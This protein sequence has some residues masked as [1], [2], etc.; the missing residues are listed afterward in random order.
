MVTTQTP[1]ISVLMAVRNGAAFIDEALAS[2]AG[3]DFKDFEIVLVD[4]G[5]GDDT[6]RLVS[7]WVDDEPRLRAF[8]LD[9]PGLSR[10]L[11]YAAAMARAPF[12]A[13]LD[14]D[15]IAL[16][17]RLGVQY[18]AMQNEPALGL[19]GSFVELIGGDGR[20]I[21]ERQLPVSDREIKHIL[22]SANPFVHSTIMMRRDAYARAGGYREGLRIC[23]DFDLWCRMAEVT[24]L[25]NLDVPLVR[26]R[27]HGDAM[28]FRQATRVALV[29]TCIVA[30]QY[31]RR[32]GE[33]EP[34]DRGMPKLRQAL[35]LLHMPRAVV[36]YRVL[37][38]TTNAARLALDFGEREQS[39]HLRRRAF[40]LLTALPL[41]KAT[42]RGIGHVAASYFRPHAR[43][44][45]Q[46]MYD[47]LLGLLPS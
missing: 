23:E 17:S 25:A 22:R 2:L 21:R 36:L 43:R 16:P 20:T 15:D 41:G 8:R 32:R 6:S 19:L 31:A 46:M 33:P 37:K 26:Y 24:D 47:R 28:S 18:A 10:S 14:C 11:K 9:R 29:D 34:F 38:A 42:W 30:A 13:R 39:R 45:R 12:L 5:S 27:M 40:R 35:A 1:A 44:R 4:N 3:Q 7:R